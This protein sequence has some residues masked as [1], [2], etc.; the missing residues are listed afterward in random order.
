MRL[1]YTILLTLATPFILLRLLWRSIRQKAYRQRI[2]ERFAFYPPLENK[3]SVWIHAVSV[4]ETHAAFPLIHFLVQQYPQFTILVTTT[5]P[6]GSAEILKQFGDHVLHYYT[7]YDL[8]RVVNRFLK[9]MSPRLCIIMETELWPNLL[10]YTHKKNIP[11]LLAN[12]RLSERS[13]KGYQRIRGLMREMLNCFTTIAA[14]SAEDGERFLKSGLNKNK[15]LITGNIKF[16][17]SIPANLIENAQALR[18]HWQQRPTWIAASTHEGEE[19]MILRAHKKI[20]HAFPNA[21]L[22][23]VPRHPERF[24]KVA[25]LCRINFSVARRNE[26]QLPDEHTQIYLGDT[27]GELRLLYASSDVAFMGGSLIP[28]GGHNPIEPALLSLPIING[29]YFHNF[30]MITTQIEQAGGLKIIHTAEE[31]ADLVILLLKEPDL[32]QHYGD[33]AKKV[34]LAHSGALQMLCEWVNTQLAIFNK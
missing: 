28:I 8:P 14:Q 30:K 7:P 15:L 13:F 3:Q 29:P 18:A 26:N 20:L 31:L 33:N 19:E 1:L 23:L 24:N 32:R 16:D 5:T 9:K 11:I 10:H 27:M 4:G 17:A 25:N 34:C 22:I 6:T 21:L 2:I 12:A